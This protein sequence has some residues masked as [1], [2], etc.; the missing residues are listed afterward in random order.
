MGDTLVGTLVNINRMT[1]AFQNK[2]NNSSYYCKGSLLSCYETV[3]IN[4]VKFAQR[5]LVNVYTMTLKT[6]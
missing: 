1:L 5:P 3:S 6:S 2:D 4:C